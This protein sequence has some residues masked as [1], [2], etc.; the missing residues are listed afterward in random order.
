GQAQLAEKR[1]SND[2]LEVAF[3]CVMLGFRGEL[4]AEPAR[5]QSWVAAAS[6]L[7]GRDYGRQWAAPPALEPVT[8]VPPLRAQ[9]R[10]QTVLLVG[11]VLLLLLVPAVAAFLVQQLGQ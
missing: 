4:S 6:S 2:A 1:P 9:R 8:R 5:L 10:L 7:V 11:G 3:L